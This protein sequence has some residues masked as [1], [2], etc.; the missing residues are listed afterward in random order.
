MTAS[1]HIAVTGASGML[2]SA[3]VP[4]LTAKGHR[5]SRLVRRA[6]HGD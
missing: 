2:G 1:L 6:P 3:L 4:S 5:V